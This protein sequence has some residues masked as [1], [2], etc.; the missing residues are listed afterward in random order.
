MVTMLKEREQLKGKMLAEE[1]APLRVTDPLWAVI[2]YLDDRLAGRPIEVP[3]GSDGLGPIRPANLQ[4]SSTSFSGPL[5]TALKEPQTTSAS[6]VPLKAV[7]IAACDLKDDD[8]VCL[9]AVLQPQPVASAQTVDSKG[10]VDVVVV[11]CSCNISAQYVAQPTSEVDKSSSLPDSER[12]GRGLKELTLRENDISHSGF[13]TALAAL[14]R[15]TVETLDFAYN[16]IINCR[17]VAP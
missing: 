4:A 10:N 13:A 12:A 6:A 14:A 9:L 3:S 15:S 1:S 17:C 11:L 8:L 7:R 5:S 2:Q 16:L